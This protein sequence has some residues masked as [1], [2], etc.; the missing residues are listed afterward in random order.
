MYGANEKQYVVK[1]SKNSA[2]EV[3]RKKILW[4]GHV[5]DGKIVIKSDVA[6]FRQD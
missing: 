4:E 6:D 1:I 5:C 3:K 2:R